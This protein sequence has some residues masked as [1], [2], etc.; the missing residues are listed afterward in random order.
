MASKTQTISGVT[1]TLS[2]GYNAAGQLSTIATPSGQQIGYGYLNNRV[3]SVTV[4]GAALVS[5]IVTTP[6]GPVGAWQWGN[7]HF[8]FRDYD[9]DGRMA[10]WSYRNGATVLRND[11]TFDA[12]SRITGIAD[13]VTPAVAGAYQYDLLDR[14]TVAQ[15]GSPITHT[16]QFSYDALGNRTTNNV[17]GAPATLIYGIATNQLQAMVGTVS[18]SYLNGATSLAYTYNNTNR[19]VQVNS[20]GTT[21]AS[22]AVNGL[23]Q[24]VRKVVGATT[25]L[26]VYDEQGR[27]VGEY[28]STGTLIQETVWLDDLPIATLRPT[29]TGVPTP[30]A[31][32]YVHPDHLGSPRAITRPSDDAL[33]WR[34]DNTDPFGN[35]VPNENP[36]ALGVFKY[37]LRFPGQYFDAELG[38][39]YNYFRDYDPAIGRYSQSDPI[40]LRGGAN[41]YSYV[42]SRPTRL[43]DPFGLKAQICCKK[44]PYLPYAHCFVNEVAD[45]PNA[46]TC[47]N[48]HSQTRRV[49][50]QGPL[51]WG[52]SQYEDAGEIKTNDPFDNPNESACGDWNGDCSVGGCIDRERAKYAN[53]SYYNAP[54]GPNSNTFAGTVARAC[55]LSG[56]VGPW[57][58]PGWSNT[59]AGPR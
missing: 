30:I 8:T 15:Q 5:G 26:F 43:F 53:P 40:G 12:A 7:G 31:L 50:L 34:W 59:P 54:L 57:Y 22:Y 52:S 11:L 1:Q 51:P 17:D 4:N 9:Q 38:T 39:H 37:G 10:S 21:V 20:G 13:P 36:A 16:Q 32:H 33:L 27:L 56:P 19:M 25:T 48:C 35:S 18:P 28:D 47:T 44:I 23:G 6:F 14:L 29:G 24:R 3:V 42:R 2:Y 45:S 46:S 49:G 41:T 55:N 58:A